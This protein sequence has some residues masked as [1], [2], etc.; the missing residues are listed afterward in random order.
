MS[1]RRR[2][3]LFALMAVAAATV[4]AAIA[5][6]YG[7]SVARRYGPLR[8]AVVARIRLAPGEPL[9]P[10][11]IDTSLEVRRIPARFVPAGTLSQPEQALGLE[12]ATEI[13]AGSYVSASLLHSPHPESGHR[14]SRP[15]LSGG[16]R[17]VQINVSGAGALLARSGGGAGARVDVVITTEPRGAGA[18]HTYVAATAVPLLALGPGPDGPG[19]ET[20]A[21]ATL[22]L[23]RGQALRLIAAEN[24]ARQVTLLPRPG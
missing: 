22:G 9:D 1:R 18:G 12:L 5:D 3:L 11:R 21:A 16:R 8:P 14:R 20:L 10:A 17:P 24:F 15:G 19:P 6:G 13:E 2:A 7:S 23:S 4:A